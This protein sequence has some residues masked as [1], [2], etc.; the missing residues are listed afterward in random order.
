M[1]QPDRTV[2]RLNPL[3]DPRWRA[4]VENHPRASVFHSAEWI[5]AIFRTYGYEP[6]A[7]TTT[8]PAAPLWDAVVA[9]RVSGWVTGARLVSLPFSDHCDP[10]TKSAPEDGPLLP[11]MDWLRSVSNCSAIELRPRTSMQPPPALSWRPKSYCLHQLDLRPTLDEIFRRCHKNCVQRRIR[12][13]ERLGIQLEE[14]ISERHIQE[15]YRLV[16]LTRRRQQLPP[17]PLIWFRNVCACL[18]SKARIMLALH[19]GRPVGGILTL[20]HRSTLYYKYG[21]S[22]KRYSN[23]GGMP[24]LLWKAIQAGK[25]EGLETFDL[26]RSDWEAPG[27]IR[28][29]D[30]LGAA[31]LN[32]TYLR[33]GEGRLSLAA[34]SW[35]MRWARTIIGRLPPR[36]LPAVGNIVYRHLHGLNA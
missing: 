17:Q 35:Q 4:L 26:G 25:S 24:F 33:F 32:L 5:E 22:D 18:G 19:S 29:K 6:V 11:E 20:R 16:V 2:Y 3:L 7:I 21:C 12:H 34:D 23:M 8:P 36:I 31:R 27:L 1:N 28:F 15:F 10:L 14:G 13:A 9:C 30:R